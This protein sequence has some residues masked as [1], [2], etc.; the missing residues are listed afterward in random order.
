MSVRVWTYCRIHAHQTYQDNQVLHHIVSEHRCSFLHHT[1]TGR[2]SRWGSAFRRCRH[3]TLGS[4]HNA[5]PWGYT[6]F[7]PWSR[8]T[9]LWS[10]WG[11]L[12]RMKR[13]Q[14]MKLVKPKAK[15]RHWTCTRYI[16]SRV[17]VLRH[18]GFFSRCYNCKPNQHNVV[19]N[20][21]LMRMMQSF[22]YF[23]LISIW[24]KCFC[25]QIKN[26]FLFRRWNSCPFFFAK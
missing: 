17:C 15:R 8:W 3:H 13:Q 10:R 20:V 23:S 5:R 25:V 18:L 16:L 26:N 22:H 21:W 24:T 6:Q 1:G 12:R 7:L 2:Q 11:A 14:E 19:C 9:A 4:H